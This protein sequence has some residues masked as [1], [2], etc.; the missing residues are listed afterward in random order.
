MGGG[1]ARLDLLRN[2]HRFFL[3][4]EAGGNFL[5]WLEREWEEIRFSPNP[6][7]LT[8]YFESDE[9]EVPFGTSVKARQFFPT[10]IT[11][12]PPT[13]DEEFRFEVKGTRH[14]V[15]RMKTAPKFLR[16]AEAVSEARSLLKIPALR[17]YLAVGYERRHFV[18]RDGSPIRF[19]VDREI[20]YWFLGPGVGGVAPLGDERILR[21]EA[22]VPVGEE[23]HPGW[24]DLRRSLGTYGALPINS[25]RNEGFARIGQYLADRFGLGVTR[26]LV[27]YEIEAKLLVHHDDPLAL[28]RQIKEWTKRETL[29]ILLPD[30]FPF[31]IDAETVNQYWAEESDVGLVD[32]LKVLFRGE[33]FNSV[34]K[35]KSE[36][37]DPEIGIVKRRE[38]KAKSVAYSPQAYREMVTSWS[39]RAR[40]PRFLGHLIRWRRA[41]WPEEV[42]SRRVYHISLDRCAAAGRQMPLWQIEIEYIG[43]IRGGAAPTRDLERTVVGELQHLV[44]CLLVCANQGGRV[45]LEPTT[46]TKFQWFAGL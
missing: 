13:W 17:P 4:P 39:E 16:L 9:H 22:K 32:G 33:Q 34:L 2:E 5:V 14:E 24:V 40:S 28:F 35:T 41:I 15:E 27:G 19:T 20:R 31:T 44:G 12:I 30:H 46:L 8:L 45:V 3:L 6:H 11:L 37:L 42:N 25:K 23:E 21:L 26:D 43:S 36:V 10:P 7:V 38:V 29:P 1:L 18:P